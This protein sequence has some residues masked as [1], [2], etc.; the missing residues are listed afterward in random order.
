MAVFN[1]FHL[2]NLRGDIFGGVTAAVIALPMALAFGV[3]SGAGAEAG[4]Y[5]AI[6]VG[7]FAALFGGTP[8]LMSEPTG[9]MT[10]V[11]TAVIV[12]LVGDN[13][14]N[15]MAMAFTVVMMAGLFQII[16]GSLRLGKYVTLMPYPVV[17]G[18][19][20]G[21]GVILVILQIA[22]LLGHAT[23][24]G[25][26]LDKLQSLPALFDDIKNNEL[27]LA[28]ITLA[29][30]FL[31]P[32][33]LRKLMP[34]Q[35]VA[36]V[37][38]TVVSL[39]IINDPGLRRIG[40][41]PAGLPD[42]RMPTFSQDQIMIMF[43]DALVLGM[44]GCIDALLTSVIADSLTR[45]RHRSN[46]ELIGQGIGN[47][48][49]GLFGGLPGAGATMGTVVGIQA[50]AKTAVAGLV[51]VLI[52]VIVVLWASG[53]TA[54]IPLAVLA[55]IAFKVGIN[56]ID[57]GFLRRA[58]KI[59]TKGAVITYAVIMLTV[60]VDL[61]VAVG[62]GLFIANIITITR[63]SELHAEDVIV[64][65]DGEQNLLELNQHEKDMLD[66][67][68]GRICLLD[69]RGTLIFGLSQTIT[70]H[71]ETF[72]RSAVLIIDLS[73]VNHIGVSAALAL[74]QAILD[75]RRTEH[76]V[77]V[78]GA[79]GQPLTRLNDLGLS[80][81]LNEDR[82]F[83]SRESAIRQATKLLSSKDRQMQSVVQP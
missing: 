2:N 83:D 50:G 12:K 23:P 24:S 14:E 13:P 40:E 44:L 70:R 3:A 32:K 52:L 8:T 78:V 19:M 77:Y 37:L 58:H 73:E 35:L 1:Q 64:V 42:F 81:L 82:F 48:A 7:L 22:P 63:L 21:I 55:G 69:L 11:F 56:I 38:G 20:S 29:V 47:M 53:L 66:M 33:K 80:R 59:S 10:V 72:S 71:S 51:R 79:T 27:I 9:P 43:I 68:N 60:F 41:I 30:L 76:E 17:S 34:P 26:M 61:I 15:G 49:S 6:F 31:L 74:E 67:A 65:N 45:T 4:L 54:H 5:G 62:L 39:W 57:W 75:M 18:F 25:A 46:K 16:F 36:L 28:T